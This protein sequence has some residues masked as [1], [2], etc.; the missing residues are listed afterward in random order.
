M[1]VFRA[2][3]Q[4]EESMIGYPRAN[5]NEERN[6]LNTLFALDCQDEDELPIRHGL[7][8]LMAMI[9][10]GGKQS[11]LWTF[12]FQPLALQNT[13]GKSLRCRYQKNHFL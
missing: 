5:D 2:L 6:S 7:V 13:F 4:P 10:M 11:F 3:I 1:L 8:N 9:L 12:A